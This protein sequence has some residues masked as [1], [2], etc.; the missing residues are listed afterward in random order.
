MSAVPSRAT[1]AALGQLIGE[2]DSGAVSSAILAVGEGSLFGLELIL[3]PAAA[4]ARRTGPPS[5]LHS[6]PRAGLAHRNLM[7]RSSDPPPEWA[8]AVE[9]G[10]QIMRAGLAE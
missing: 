10:R 8:D 7:Q 3:R 6:E 9:R 1:P 5:P 4:P 2:P